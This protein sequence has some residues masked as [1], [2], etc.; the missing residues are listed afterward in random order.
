MRQI[1]FVLALLCGQLAFAQQTPPA[2]PAAPPP[3]ESTATS[4]A[5]PAATPPAD[6]AATPPADPATPPAPATPAAPAKP[7]GPPR[8]RF[9]TSLGSFVV[10]L[11][12]ERAPL[13]VEAFLR[14][15]REGFY[16]GTVFHRVINNFVA[17]GGGY[18]VNYQVK[19]SRHGKVFNESGNGL[20]NRRGT[21]GMARTEAPH[22]ATTQFFLNLA[23]NPDL[24]PLPTRW[25]YAVF[26]EVVEGMDV[27]DRMG[28]VPTGK[29]ASFDQDAPLR[30]L[31]IERARILE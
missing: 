3:A 2:D 14:N 31:V 20:T 6:P 10:Q 12:E 16:D 17:Q 5:D 15:V 18:D 28:H 21:I 23:D 4:P 24:N 7:A 29:V 27:V 8:V 22:S 13:T 11:D 9:D 1:A 26:G 30:P 19:M 25:G